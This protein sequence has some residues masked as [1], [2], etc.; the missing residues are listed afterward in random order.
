MTV[1]ES[2][3]DAVGLGQGGPNTR[4]CKASPTLERLG[5]ATLDRKT[6]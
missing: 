6:M 2:L 4:T 3:K 1:T 5:H